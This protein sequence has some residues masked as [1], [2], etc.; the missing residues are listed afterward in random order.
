MD[1]QELLLVFAVDALPVEVELVDEALQAE[2]AFL[3]LE[4]VTVDVPLAKFV[5][6]MH[7]DHVSADVFVLINFFCL[8]EVS[9]LGE[10]LRLLAHIAAPNDAE[11]RPQ[12]YLI[13]Y[14]SLP[15]LILISI[16]NP[17][18]LDLGI[19]A[20]VLHLPVLLV[21][22][23]LLLVD[24]AYIETVRALKLELARLGSEQVVEGLV[25]VVALEAEDLKLVVRHGFVVEVKLL[26]EDEELVD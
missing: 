6:G 18:R 11:R 25:G 12:V 19:V 4:I 22:V 9:F 8:E 16:N 20:I 10:E 14:I 15:V 5:E 24:I 1:L 2:E 21:D 17:A 26:V 23:R 7:Q 13:V 3:V